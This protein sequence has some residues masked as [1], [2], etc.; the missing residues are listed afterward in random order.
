MTTAAVIYGIIPTLPEAMQEDA[1]HYI[2][3]LKEKAAVENTPTPLPNRGWGCMKGLITIHDDFE[4]PLE[5]FK[6]YM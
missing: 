5:D 4:D 1:L 6:D 3:A 2:E